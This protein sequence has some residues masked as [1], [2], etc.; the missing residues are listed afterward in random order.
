MKPRQP[1][2]TALLVAASVAMCGVRHGLPP[3][4]L[5]MAGR[6]LDAAA[7]HGSWLAALARRRPGQWLLAA[8]QRLVLPGLASHHCRRKAWFWTRLRDPEQQDRRLVWLGVG[9]D[10]LGRACLDAG[11][12]AGILE[13][14]H[15]DTL[16]RRRQLGQAQ[17]V[18]MAPLV[19]PADAAK[20][21]ALCRRQPTTLVCEGLLMYLRPRE[22]ARLLS[23]LARLPVP[24]ALL[25]SALDSE[26]PGGRG[27]R[28]PSAGVRAWLAIKRE[29]F[30]WRTGPE[31]MA[32]V[33][34]SAGYR[35]RAA[36][37]GEGF[38]EYAMDAVPVT[39]G[40]LRGWSDVFYNCS[41]TGVEQNPWPSANPP[42]TLP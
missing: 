36:W 39:S 11:H 16:Q 14:D 28:R 34:A 10:G 23:R 12:V 27:F 29:P 6:A 1:S 13:T 37:D 17:G 26:V 41:T 38:G 20:L 24:P 4:A 18:P 32:A 2:A 25:F 5:G 7:A 35:V 30:L 31:R 15:P 42:K 40:P 8:A 21:L 9:F 22:L 33:L 3:A 19:L